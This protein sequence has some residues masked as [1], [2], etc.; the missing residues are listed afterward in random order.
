MLIHEVG[1]LFILE[2]FALHHMAPVAG[3]IANAQQ[4]GPI[5]FLRLLQRL[6]PPGIPIHR[7]MCVL[8]QV[9]AGLMNEPVGV[10]MLC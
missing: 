5:E 2:G 9:G 3:R 7:V 8:E 6:F 10:C 1:N 4:N